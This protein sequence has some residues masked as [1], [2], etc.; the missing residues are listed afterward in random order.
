MPLLSTFANAGA[1]A[2]GFAGAGSPNAPGIGT[3]TAISN[4]AATVSFTAPASDGGVPITQ[5]TAVSSPGG[6]TGV[7]N[8]AGSGTITVNGLTTGTTYT[9]TVFATNALGNSP[10]SAP[11]NTI[12]TFGVPDAPI[13]GTASAINSTSASVS[14][15][16]PAYNGG[17]T[18][19]SY[20]AVSS[21]GGLTGSVS[22]SGSG[23][24][25]VSGLSA[26]TTYTFSVYATNT[27][28]NSANSSSSN[29]ITTPA[30]LVVSISPTSS[31][32]NIP[33]QSAPVTSN[34]AFTVF[35]VSGTGDVTVQEISS[36]VGG[37]TTVTPSSFSLGAGGSRSVTVT[38]TSPD[39][40][41][42]NDFY[43]YSFAVL[44]NA[45]SY[46]IYTLT[47]NRV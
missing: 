44:T 9:F 27:Y 12:K 45:G 35:Q 41:F 17:A 4:V 3:A 14:F 32:V 46:P 1:R 30:I 28:G 11:S 38:C 31:A 10:S 18:I 22:Q 20:T 23:S 43:T 6:I 13:I 37:S 47:Q 19:T 40:N 42:G 29:S 26:S 21:P 5:Y 33:R 16:A 2:Y 34:G 8:Q 15:T 25:T 39:G 7:V 36:P 24:I